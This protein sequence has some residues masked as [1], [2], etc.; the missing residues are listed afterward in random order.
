MILFYR[1]RS[2]KI[3]FTMKQEIKKDKKIQLLERVFGY[4]KERDL[5]VLQAL[6]DGY[7][8][9][10]TVKLVNNQFPNSM[11]TDSS[12]VSQIAKANR[13]L[14]DELTFKSE[15]AMKAGRIRLANRI[16]KKKGDV[17]KK[18]TLDWAEFIRREQE[19][20]G[21]IPAIIIFERGIPVPYE[22][23]EETE[24]EQEAQITEQ[25]EAI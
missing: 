2:H 20:E 21:N 9:S 25:K 10:D 4:N 16:L 14:L 6:A 8:R 15:F 23:I 1:E 22:E 17:S 12:R 19:G 7:N 13:E 11:L 3:I 18:D 24:D 5:Y